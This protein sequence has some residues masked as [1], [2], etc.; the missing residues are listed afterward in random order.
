MEH[1]R[2]LM[3]QIEKF[4]RWRFPVGQLAQ[5][6]VTIIYSECKSPGNAFRYRVRQE[7]P[8]I[9]TYQELND[10]IRPS[11]GQKLNFLAN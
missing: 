5:E 6:L 10:Q 11:D 7:I 2:N 8:C 3:Q 4:R 1:M 9:D